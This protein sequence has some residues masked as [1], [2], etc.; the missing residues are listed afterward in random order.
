VILHAQAAAPAAAPASL[1]CAITHYQPT[2]ADTAFEHHKYSDAET[3]YRAALAKNATD[4]GAMTG[5]IRILLIENKGSEALATVQGFDKAYPDNSTVLTLLGE[6][7][8]RLGEMEDVL[9]YLNRA[10]KMDPC[11]AWAHYQASRYLA[12]SAMF[13]RSKSQINVAHE[14]E[15]DSPAIARRWNA[16]NPPTVTPEQRIATLTERLTKPDLTPQEHAAI[17]AALRSL[18]T[19]Q[20][21][22]CQAITPIAGTVEKLVPLTANGSVYGV[23]L[24][25]QLNGKNRTFQVDTG[26]SGLLLSRS[27]ALAA[28]LTPEMD[29]KMTGGFGDEGPVSGYVTHVDDIKIG[30]LEF[31]NCI[32][33]VV[34]DKNALNVDGVIGTNVFKNYL[35]TIDFPDYQLRVDPL[36]SRPGENAQTESLSTTGGDVDAMDPT[37]QDRYVAPEMKDWYGFYRSGSMV[38]VPTVIG[39]AP[40]KLFILSS[41]SAMGLI[42]PSAAKLVSSISNTNSVSV[43]GLN[44]DVNKVA[45]AH[46]LTIT[47]ANVSQEMDDM[48]SIDTSKITNAVGV[49]ISG[50]IGFPTLKQLT[51]SLD[52]RDNLMHVAYDPRY[53]HH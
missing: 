4:P 19:R 7:Y 53:G 31:K 23:G 10:M 20:R 1:S 25:L 9:P 21:G 2:D 37:P 13:A 39:K 51:V 18:Q 30:P 28:G 3:M 52:Y 8:M 33:S 12:L 14:L 41:T 6:V 43:R 24:K 36:P 42:S 45:V 15:P 27:S 47:F 17:E 26:A 29:V 35:V 46:H 5:R 32:A 22:D 38:I 34:E 16:S 40:T 50:F 49:E 48:T 44:G 11:N